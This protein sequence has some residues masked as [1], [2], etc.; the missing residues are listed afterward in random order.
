MVRARV[1]TGQALGARLLDGDEALPLQALENRERR[2][3]QFTAFAIVFAAMCD[4]REFKRR[5]LLGSAA[6]I[7]TV[8]QA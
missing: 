8:S 4:R 2:R 7:K 6:K 3:Q 1:P 5:E